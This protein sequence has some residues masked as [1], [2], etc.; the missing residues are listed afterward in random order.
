MFEFVTKIWNP[1]VGCKHNCKY[2][3]ARKLA[4]TKLANCWPYNL[5]LLG[6][7]CANG[8]QEPGRPYRFY[9]CWL[10]EQRFKQ[11]FGE[12]DFV[13][14]SDMGDL[15]GEWVPAGYIER[16][17]AAMRSS[18]LAQFLL[19]TKNPKRYY[20]EIQH[21]PWNCVLGVT[22]ESNRDYPDVS[23]APD[24]SERLRRLWQLKWDANVSGRFKR[25]ISV[26]PI[27]DFDLKPFADKLI[28]L[29]PW[30]VAIGF[31]NYKCGLVEPTL[32]KTMQLID[33]LEKAGIKVYRKSLREGGEKQ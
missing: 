10:N 8:L 24:Q 20:F 12:G 9:G 21:I 5:P 1:V 2:C 29:E 15:F 11:R 31:D 26:E 13:F 27:M 32:E 25:F 17:C 3:W 23:R 30:A 33:R 14:V 28:D 4:E 19:M 6:S 18:P 22:V 16:V 7:Q